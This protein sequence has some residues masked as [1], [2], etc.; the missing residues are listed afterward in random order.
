MRQLLEIDCTSKEDN[1]EIIRRRIYNDI[2][3]YDMIAA[4]DNVK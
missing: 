1:E 4:S 3:E 2:Y